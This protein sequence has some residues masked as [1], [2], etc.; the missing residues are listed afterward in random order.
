MYWSRYLSTHSLMI[1][2]RL[3]HCRC[4][5]IIIQFQRKN[6]LNCCGLIR[7][8]IKGVDHFACRGRGRR[9]GTKP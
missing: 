6:K 1:L 5:R 9:W 3:N 4:T 8:Q 2:M 7:M